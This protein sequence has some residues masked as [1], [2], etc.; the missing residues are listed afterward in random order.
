VGPHISPKAIQNT[1]VNHHS[2]P[3]SPTQSTTWVNNAAHSSMHNLCQP[4]P[5][6]LLKLDLSDGY[7]MVHLFSEAA[8]E[9][10]VVLPDFKRN[11]SLVALPSCIPM[12]WTHCPPHFCAFTETI[13]DVA[14][15]NLKHAHFQPPHNL[16]YISQAH[17][18]LSY[19]FFQLCPSNDIP[20]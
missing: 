8:L 18:L 9:S 16:E 13:A 14:K 15:N 3:L 5:P 1:G 12:G 20:S 19:P 17:T 2:L 4:L 11:S 6:L 10:A 7:Y